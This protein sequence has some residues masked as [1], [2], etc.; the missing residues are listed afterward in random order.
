MQRLLKCFENRWEDS[1]EICKSRDWYHLCCVLS[2]C[3][4]RSLLWFRTWNGLLAVLMVWFLWFPAITQNSEVLE[5]IL[6]F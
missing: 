6:A 4:L 1:I 2:L 5:D 3:Q